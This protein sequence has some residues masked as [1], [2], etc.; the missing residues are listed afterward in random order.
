MSASNATLYVC[1]KR[2]LCLSLLLCLSRVV[3]IVDTVSS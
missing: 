2:N 1:K 3:T